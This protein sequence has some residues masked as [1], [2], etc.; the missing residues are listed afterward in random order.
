MLSRSRS[1]IVCLMIPIAIATT[2][3]CMKKKP[4]MERRLPEISS[5]LTGDMGANGANDAFG[6]S[7]SGL[8]GSQWSADGNAPGMNSLAGTG[9]MLPGE[10]GFGTGTDSGANSLDA[11]ATDSAG[12]IP[13]TASTAGVEAGAFMSEL[14]MVHFPFDSAEITADWQTVLN[15]HAAWINN[16]SSV[17]V[18]IEGHCDDRGTEEYNIALGQRR[19]DE[20]RN[21]LVGQGVDPNRL[22]TISYGEL[23]PLSFEVNEEAHML[24]RRAMF[25]V[26][27]VDN[28]VAAAGAF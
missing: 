10:G 4:K 20:V 24:N 21:Y 25:L 28:S 7:R 5:N 22:S 3:G 13:N 16:N 26:Y 19:A 14:E 23:R 17:M 8:P 2:T 11:F 9:T 12:T 18:Q 15:G 27:E 6:T 1:L